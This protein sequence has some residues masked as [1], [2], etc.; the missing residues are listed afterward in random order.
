VVLVKANA[1]RHKAMSY[2]HMLKTEAE[3][4]AQ[5]AALLNKAH[6][7]DEAEKMCVMKAA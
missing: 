7:A 5:I 4:K 3:L 6:S 1:S 2:S